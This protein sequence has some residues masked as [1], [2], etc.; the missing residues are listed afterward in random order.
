MRVATA[1]APA[2]GS[3]PGSGGTTAGADADGRDRVT[4]RFGAARTLG[5]TLLQAVVVA[6]GVT[7]LTFCAVNLLPGSAA[8]AILGESATPQS[9]QA[10][11][12]K[13]HQNQPFFVQY[14]D[15]LS[16]AVHGNLGDSLNGAQPVSQIIS[17]RLPVT[18][19][20][21]IVAMILSVV[22]AVPVALVSA[23]RPRGVIDRIGLAVSM[24]GIST[25]NFAIALV[26]ILIFAVHVHVFPALGFVPLNA[27]FGDNLRTILLPAIALAFPLYCHYAR[28]LRADLLDQL[29]SEDYVMT[30]RAK[31]VSPSGIIV[32]H[33]LRNSIFSLLTMIGLNL[34]VL[35]GG[36]VIIEQVFGLPGM[37]QALFQ[38][39]QVKDVPVV[40]GIVLILSIAV[41][42]ANTAT[43]L[44]YSVLD[45]RIRDGSRSS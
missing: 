6:V 42:L 21:V 18:L 2:P 34:G 27:G 32:R 13:L 22:V 39:I 38:G 3:G 26:L 28:I 40:Q 7:F 25:P 17:A 41:V 4:D 5:R 14:W 1:G 24:V 11:T 12:V 8:E 36:T 20:L 29:N 45:P 9:V 30:A 16:G 33:V 31:G 23:Y 19:E 10:L 35:I 43:D 37:G 44:L 15:W